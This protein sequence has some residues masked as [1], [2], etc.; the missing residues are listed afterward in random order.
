ML[1]KKVNVKPAINGYC[2]ATMVIGELMQV[3]KYGIGSIL[4]EA[5]LKL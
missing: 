3:V 4:F 5:L 1:A 2:G